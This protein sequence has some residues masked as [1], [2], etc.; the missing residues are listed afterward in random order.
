MEILKRQ[1]ADSIEFLGERRG[2]LHVRRHIAV[3]PL[4]KGIPNFKPMR[5]AMLR[6][7]TSE[8]LLR[9]FDEAAAFLNPLQV[10]SRPEADCFTCGY[11]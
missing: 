6:A 5:V 3:T 11:A 4:F 2:I 7:D 10:H 8:E 1:V 9:L